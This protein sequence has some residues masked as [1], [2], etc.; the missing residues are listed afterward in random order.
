MRTAGCVVCG[1]AFTYGT[2]GRPAVTCSEACR[3]ER[4]RD[5][6]R[7]RAERWARRLVARELMEDPRPN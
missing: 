2:P 5:L 6:A 3:E 7:I 1:R 4:S